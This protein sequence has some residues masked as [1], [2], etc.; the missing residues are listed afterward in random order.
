MS[1]Y[2]GDPTSSTKRVRK[3]VCLS[4]QEWVGRHF[5]GDALGHGQV[6]FL[7]R[8]RIAKLDAFPTEAAAMEYVRQHT[9]I[10]VPK[11]YKVY[12]AADGQ[13]HIVMERLPGTCASQVVKDW[14]QDQ[15]ETFS[16]DLADCLHQLRTLQ[17]PSPRFIGSA[18]SKGQLIDDRLSLNPCGPFNS[19]ADFHTY[20]RFGRPLDHWVGVDDVTKV[21]TRP[22]NNYTPTFSHSDL[23]PKN[24]LVAPD[25]HITGVVD[26]EYAGWYPDYWEYT[27]MRRYE[28]AA[29]HWKNFYDAVEQQPAIKKYPDEMACE[30]V[31]WMRMGSPHRYCDPPWQPGDDEKAA[32]ERARM[33]AIREE[34]RKKEAER[35]EDAVP[36]QPKTDIRS[37]TISRQQRKLRSLPK[38]GTKD[39]EPNA[40]QSQR[41]T[42]SASRQAM[43]DALS[44]VRVHA[45]GRTHNVGLYVNWD[46]PEELE[47]W[48]RRLGATGAKAARQPPIGTLPMSL[49]G[50]YASF[51]GKSGLTLER[52]LVYAGLKRSGYVVQRAPTWGDESESDNTAEIAL[53][54]LLA[55][56]QALDAV[57]QIGP[58]KP[59]LPCVRGRRPRHNGA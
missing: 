30:A 51:I 39:F 25:G 48:R 13:Q 55:G 20:L 49:Q 40:T 35:Q 28:D 50:A 47:Q 3:P 26:W 31:I 18:A 15:K 45:S 36:G 5:C 59:R 9:T 10:P 2:Q 16:R 4:V 42:L 32:V 56:I 34:H 37:T 23:C 41:H 46:R 19:I 6:V 58:S 24:I 33:D 54:P 29:P 11:I 22:E 1:A 43:Y 57:P 17:P 27:K 7:P 21:H 12:P 53:H 38:R 52:Y 14:S 44:A 8:H